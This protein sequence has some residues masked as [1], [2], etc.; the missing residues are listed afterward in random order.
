M[1]TY[2]ILLQRP[3]TVQS[4]I[5]PNYLVGI[6]WLGAEVLTVCLPICCVNQIF[7]Q[8]SNQTRGKGERGKDEGKSNYSILGGWQLL[9]VFFLHP[10]FSFLIPFIVSHQENRLDV[11]TD[12]LYTKNKIASRVHLKALLFQFKF[13]KKTENKGRK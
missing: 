7:S 12:S 6:D 5:S 9:Q 10:P 2:K 1:P 3:G 13:C 11:R 8:V 4:Y